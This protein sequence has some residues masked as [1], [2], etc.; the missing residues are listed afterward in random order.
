MDM[1]R[2]HQYRTALLASLAIGSPLLGGSRVLAQELPDP[3]THHQVVYHAGEERVYL[4]GGS[5]PRDGAH[6]FF[7]DMWVWEDDVWRRVASLPF[8]RS[9]HR[10]AYDPDRNTIVLFGGGFDRTFAADSVLWGWDGWEW[11]PLGISPLGGLGEPGMCHDRKRSRLVLFGGWDGANRLTGETW[12]WTGEAFERI[13]VSGPSARGGH[14][15][16]YDS[17]RQR[18]LLFGGRSEG[19]VLSD[20]WDWDGTSWQRIETPG[21]PARWAAAATT[22]HANERVVL[23]SGW[24][25]DETLLGDTWSWDGESWTLISEAGPTVRI[26][27]QLAF[28]GDG[29]LLFGGRT[30][31][32]EGFADLNDTWLLRSN[33]WVRIR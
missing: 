24:R 25:E 2:A 17:K 27:G 10:V 23:F 32:A 12:E 14:V 20:T 8:P 5:T 11:K 31:T 19:G 18:C 30:R 16:V 21:P 29:V 13:D 7:D 33:A 9:S 6:H 15:F 3:R 4:L 28:D 1:S 22:D 26:G